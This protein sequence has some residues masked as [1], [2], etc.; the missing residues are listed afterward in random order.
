[1]LHCWAPFTSI[2]CYWNSAC[3]GSPEWNAFIRF[4]KTWG[5]LILQITPWLFVPYEHWVFLNILRNPTGFVYWLK[6]PKSGIPGF[7]PHVDVTCITIYSLWCLNFLGCVKDYCWVCLFGLV[8]FSFSPSKSQHWTIK[9]LVCCTLPPAAFSMGSSIGNPQW[10]YR[11]TIPS[12]LNGWS[13]AKDFVICHYNPIQQNS[14]LIGMR[15]RKPF[16]WLHHKMINES[17]LC[18]LWGQHPKE[19]VVINF[20]QLSLPLLQN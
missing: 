20:V 17:N 7:M 4:Q 18:S 8:C 19:N 5:K 10:H 16:I 9:L 3:F 1:M 13:H 2:T 6:H 12:D 11:V 14:Y 15:T